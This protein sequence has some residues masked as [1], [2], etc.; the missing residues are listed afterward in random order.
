MSLKFTLHP[1]VDGKSIQLSFSCVY[2]F[3]KMVWRS[4][5][6]M[7]NI[8]VGGSSKIIVAGPCGGPL[9]SAQGEPDLSGNVGS[10]FTPLSQ[11]Q[12]TLDG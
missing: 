11:C 8:C 7:L 2:I 9:W 12:Y 5:F 4:P 6:S 10:V 1:L 3:G